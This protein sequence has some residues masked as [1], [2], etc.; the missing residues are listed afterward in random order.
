MPA[1]CS[2]KHEANS[3]TISLKLIQKWSLEFN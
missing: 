1:D 2:Q 3:S